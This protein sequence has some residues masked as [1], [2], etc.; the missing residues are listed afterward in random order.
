MPSLFEELRP[1]TWFQVCAQ[2]DALAKIESLRSRGF[3]G[4][5]VWISGPSG[6]GKS[7]IAR[8]LAAEIADELGTFE[9]S[10]E[11]LTLKEIEAI[12]RRYRLRAM[13]KGGWGIIVNEAHGMAGPCVTELLDV[14]E[15]PRLPRHVLWVFTTTETMCQNHEGEFRLSGSR[16]NAGP[17]LS[18][19]TVLE[20]AVNEQRFASFA[21]HAARKA[22][23]DGQPFEAYLALVRKCRGNLRAV[24]GEVEAGKMKH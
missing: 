13:G 22:G 15:T 7:S 23:L 8:L 16:T 6:T 19:C 24:L 11:K 1:R 18:R 10:A 4:R 2:D 5:A 17:L 3:G 14:L 12:E 21:Q 20:T 9:A